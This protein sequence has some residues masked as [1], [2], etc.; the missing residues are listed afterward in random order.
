MSGFRASTWYQVRPGAISTCSATGRPRSHGPEPQPGS[1]A[2]TAAAATKAP[3][4]AHDMSAIV[5]YTP[6][7]SR[8]GSGAAA[9]FGSTLGAPTSFAAWRSGAIRTTLQASP[10]FSI[11]RMTQRRG[12]ELPALEPVLGRARE[13]VVVVVPGLAHRRQGDPPH[14]GRLVLDLEPAL[15]EVVADRVDRPGHVVQEEGPH[16]AAPDEAAQRALER[17]AVQR[18]AEQRRDAD[19]REREP[20]E[21]P[22]DA[23]HARVLVEL[24]G[25]LLPVRQAV[26]LHQP[27]GVR[28]PQPGQAGAVADVR[29]VRVAL[30]VGV[31]V[32]LAVVGD[33]VHHRALEP[34]RAEDRERVLGRLV[35][36]EGAVGEQPVV[37]DGDAEPEHQVGDGHDRQVDPVDPLVP[38]QDHC[39]DQPQE[40]DDHADQVHGALSSR[41]HGAQVY[42]HQRSFLEVFSR[43][44]SLNL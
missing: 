31:R 20:R 2:I 24:A 8:S 33:P 10:T 21:H 12:V 40:R 37:A 17:E 18:P 1:A 9:G 6:A 35:G 29:G 22:A 36:P 25:V 4:R 44:A 13:G 3:A 15:A 34:H 27:A 26:G 28:V 38:E 43:I 19:R 14:V 41:H 16:E 39:R 7:G 32:V 5:A 23:A 42:A 11:A 30:L